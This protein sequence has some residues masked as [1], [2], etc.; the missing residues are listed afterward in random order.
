METETRM[1]P[2]INKRQQHNVMSIIDQA[3]KEG[4][5]IT[6]RGQPPPAKGSSF[7]PRSSQIEMPPQNFM[8]RKFSGPCFP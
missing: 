5:E 1:G 6:H 4:A 8:S 3:K 2:L 7:S